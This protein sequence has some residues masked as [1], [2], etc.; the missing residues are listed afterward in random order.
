LISSTKSFSFT[1]LAHKPLE[2]ALLTLTNTAG[3]HIFSGVPGR[4]EGRKGRG[5]T[6]ETVTMHS[7]TITTSHISLPEVVVSEGME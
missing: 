4:Q 2:Q 3:N 7:L 6:A 1:A 5:K